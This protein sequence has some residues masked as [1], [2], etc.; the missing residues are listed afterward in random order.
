MDILFSWKASFFHIRI[1]NFSRI[2]TNTLYIL[3]AHFSQVF[4]RS[5]TFGAR[6]TVSLLSR[7][8]YK[9]QSESVKVIHLWRPRHSKSTL[10]LKLQATEQPCHCPMSTPIKKDALY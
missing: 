5:V 2:P 7:L 10:P 6:G 3:K 4:F 8:S 9:S 1:R